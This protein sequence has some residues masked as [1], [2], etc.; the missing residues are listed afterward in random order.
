MRS[1]SERG[2]ATVEAAFLLP[3]LL[4]VLGALLQPSILLYDRC[5]MQAAAAETCRV[6]ATGTAGDTAVRAFALRRLGAIPDIA[7]FH[8]DGRDSW[9]VSWEG[10]GS[11]EATVRIVNRARPLPLFGVLAGLRGR[12]D[13]DGAIVQEVEARSSPVPQWARGSGSPDEWI[14]A[15]Q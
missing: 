11:G 5:A 13:A 3:V 15:W 10:T 14:G 8:E 6:V 4:A 9:E 2:Q 7:A 1:S 12:V